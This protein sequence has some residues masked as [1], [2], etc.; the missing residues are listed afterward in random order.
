MS[1]KARLNNL[2][3]RNKPT[4]VNLF[5]SLID[6]IENGTSNTDDLIDPNIHG[7]FLKICERQIADYK[8]HHNAEA[9][10]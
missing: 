5:P 9:N 1:V 4:V 7:E 10:T 2:E 8:E 6:D 3:R